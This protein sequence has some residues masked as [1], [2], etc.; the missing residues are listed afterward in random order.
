M[1][2]SGHFDPGDAFDKPA[3]ALLDELLRWT[4]ALKTLR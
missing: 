3:K 4:V 1:K 2:E